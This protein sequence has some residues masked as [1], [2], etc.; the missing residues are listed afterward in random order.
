MR[1]HKIRL[2]NVTNSQI[3]AAIE[4]WLHSERDR[5]IL[6]YKLIDGLTY[7]Q[8]CD[9]LYSDHKI[10]LSERQLQNIV[11]KAESILFKHL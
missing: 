4:E 6:K 7:L 8:I 2:E 3:S 10:V 9:K 1:K 11:Y 5:L